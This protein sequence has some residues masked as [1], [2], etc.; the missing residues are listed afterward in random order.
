MKNIFLIIA[1]ATSLACC[2]AAQE[3]KDPANM[4]S[5]KCTAVNSAVDCTKGELPAVVTQFGPVVS[6]LI[7]EAT[8]ADGNVDW[9][10]VEK[11]LGSL[12]SSYGMCV[13]GNIIQNYMVSPPKLSPG[14]V[15]PSMASL[16]AGFAHAKTS[17]WKLDAGAKVHTDKGDIQ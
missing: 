3:C 4:N 8:G 10:H 17:L 13:L 11:L 5:I 12:G 1:V 15:K 7:D 6:Q 16:K 14:E 2:G 9:G